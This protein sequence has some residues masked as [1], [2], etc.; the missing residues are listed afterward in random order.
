MSVALEL[1]V[2]FSSTLEDH[3]PDHRISIEC[4][5]TFITLESGASI[6]KKEN[7]AQLA[8]IGSAEVNVA[9]LPRKGMMT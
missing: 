5:D 9:D 6:N 4:A 7:N 1:S 3:F 8:A 2:L